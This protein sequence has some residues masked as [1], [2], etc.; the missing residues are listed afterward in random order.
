MREL[1]EVR[2]KKM[3][4]EE[5]AGKVKDPIKTDEAEK[6][7]ELRLERAAAMC[8]E[9]A[10]TLIRIERQFDAIERRYNKLIEQ[11][12]IFASRAAAR[13]RYVLQEGAE[14]DRTVALVDLL[15]KSRRKE[16]ISEKLAERIRLSRPHRALTDESLY[17]RKEKGREAFVP[18]AVSEGGQAEENLESFV[19]KPLYTRKELQEFKE[20][21]SVG[22]VFRTTRQT[23]RSAE[24]LEK[25]FFIW[26]EATENAF[27]SG[28]I[29]VGEE[30]ETEQG[31]RFST[32]E[33]RED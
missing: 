31:M 4:D 8:E 20:R 13:I 24:D 7:K 21:N 29:T 16:E 22:N 11:K 3:K 12:T 23:V 17:K 26:Q 30:E 2:Q 14:E 9:A 28:E 19:L 25:L 15:N 1:E 10:D 32:L 33:I 18:A 6:I 5:N 27:G